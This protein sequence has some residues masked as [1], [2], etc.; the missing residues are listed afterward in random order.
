MPG[1]RPPKPTQLKVLQGNPGKRALNKAEP[2]YS[3]DHLS[4]PRWLNAEARKEWR[5]LL[6]MLKAERVVT[7]ADRSVLAACCQSYARWMQAEEVL[8]EKGFTEEIEVQNSKGEVI[9]TRH[10][11]RPEVIIAQ[12]MQEMMLRAA[13][14]LGLTPS[15][16]AK[17]SKIP[18]AQED[19]FAAFL[20]K[21]QANG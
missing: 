9:G 17:V 8:E 6:P 18:E 2:Q 15:D 20:S 7:A 21:K 13:A 19:P 1:G 3:A 12:K 11:V 16:R 4:C 5:R 10:V 14:K